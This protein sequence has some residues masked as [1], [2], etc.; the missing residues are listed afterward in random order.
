MIKNHK[1]MFLLGILV[2]GVSAL[3]SAFNFPMPIEQTTETPEPSGLCQVNAEKIQLL[4]KTE[5]ARW[6]GEKVS[7]EVIEV[8]KLSINTDEVKIITYIRQPGYVEIHTITQNSEA[9]LVGMDDCGDNYRFFYLLFT[10]MEDLAVFM[11]IRA[12]ETSPQPPSHQGNHQAVDVLN[13]GFFQ[14]F[15]WIQIQEL[16]NQQYDEGFSK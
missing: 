3:I 13:K 5:G 11:A 7:I 10:R 1:T 2:M 6:E 9:I 12:N 15:N 8:G 16:L 4:E 14:F